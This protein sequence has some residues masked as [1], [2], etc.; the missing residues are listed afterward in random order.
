[1]ILVCIECL[2]HKQHNKIAACLFLIFRGKNYST[3]R[4]CKNG[5]FSCRSYTVIGLIA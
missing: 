5:K 2:K 3:F 4:H 1:M